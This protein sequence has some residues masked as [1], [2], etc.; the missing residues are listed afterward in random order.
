MYIHLI[1]NNKILKKCPATSKKYLKDLTHKKRTYV[2]S[3][4]FISVIICTMVNTQD[5]SYDRLLQEF[6]LL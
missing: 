4:Q 6:Q 1:N 3:T 2:Q 5:A